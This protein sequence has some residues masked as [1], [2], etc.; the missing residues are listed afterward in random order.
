MVGVSSQTVKRC[1]DKD[2]DFAARESDARQ[3]WLDDIEDVAMKRALEGYEETVTEYDADGE[4]KSRKVSVKQDNALLHRL[5]E[6]V[7]PTTRQSKVEVSGEIKTTVGLDKILAS[8]NEEQQRLL[9]RII[10]IEVAKRKERSPDG[11]EDD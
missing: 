6:R 10:E 1:A 5:M 9:D 8:L 2:H 3:A 4:I 7:S 11:Q